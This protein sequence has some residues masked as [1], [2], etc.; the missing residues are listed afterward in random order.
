MYL[1]VG[2]KILRT[3]KVTERVINKLKKIEFT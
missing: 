2:I 1:T 3:R